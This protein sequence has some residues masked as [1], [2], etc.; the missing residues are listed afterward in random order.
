MTNQDPRIVVLDGYTLNPGD[1]GWEALAALG[2]LTV[3]ER[4]PE[5]QILERAQDAQIILTN[6]IRL[7]AATLQRLP[8]LRYIGVLATGYDV[9]DVHAAAEQDITVTNIPAYSTHSVA[10]VLIAQ[11]LT[12]C[13]RVQQHSDAVQA[14]RWSASADFSFQ[15]SPQ[16]EL[17]EKMMGIIGFGRIGQRLG[18]IASALG[19]QVQAFSR[20]QPA[21]D[22]IPSFRWVDLDTLLQTSDVISLNCP[23]TPET[24]GLIDRQ[25][26]DQMKP[27]AI[28]LNAS[29][30]GLVVDQDLADAL[31]EGRIAGAGLDVLSSEPPPADHPLLHAQNVVITPHIA[32]A[33]F[34]ARQRLMQMAVDNVRAFLNGDPQ[35]RVTG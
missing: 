19:M 3:Y 21:I 7:D 13:H 25:A 14:G 1:L 16:T 24:A 32:W 2:Q 28:L 33:T 18:M 35:N 30:G 10:Q 34:E 11:L 26:L 17:A 27:S 31:N 20:S 8:Y 22:F 9:V 5:E 6:K 23:L 4:T 15:E 29:R 12:F